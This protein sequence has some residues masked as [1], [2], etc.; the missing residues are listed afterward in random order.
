MVSRNDE[1]ARENDAGN[2][3][4]LIESIKN[5][6]FYINNKVVIMANV[7]VSVSDEMKKKM[8]D[9]G[10]INWSEVARLA[11]SERLKKLELT[12]A[13]A[14]E[15]QLTEKDVEEIG[16]KIKREIAKKHGL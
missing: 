15:S 5:I 3:I 14:S 6:I 11:F 1:R 4:V 13:L 8:D 16:K 12:D 2:G 10:I 7:C 9:Y